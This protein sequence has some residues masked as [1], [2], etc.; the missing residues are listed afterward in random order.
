MIEVPLPWVTSMQP[1]F[2][3]NFFSGP[4]D[5][6]MLREQP[7]FIQQ[8]VSFSVFILIYFEDTES[9]HPFNHSLGTMLH[10]LCIDFV[11]RDK[12][13]TVGIHYNIF[14]V[15]KFIIY[16]NLSISNMTIPPIILIRFFEKHQN[17]KHQDKNH[18]YSFIHIN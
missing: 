16:L 18:F 10:Y 4:Q 13:I 11:E 3:R 9:V 1:E 7:S 12:N 8:K 6:K 15:D 2:Y 14:Q 5:V 17:F